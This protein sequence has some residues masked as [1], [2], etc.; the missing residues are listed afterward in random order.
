MPESKNFE[1]KNID[2]DN[3]MIE[4][5]SFEEIEERLAYQ[6]NNGCCFFIFN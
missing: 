3:C 4:E 5:I 1:I 6:T 2:L